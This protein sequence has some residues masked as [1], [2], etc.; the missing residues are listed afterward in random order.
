MIL[1]QLILK[2]NYRHIIVRSICRRCTN[3]VVCID[4]LLTIEVTR[5]VCAKL[6]KDVTV[7]N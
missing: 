3:T 2:Y 6:Q 4:Q 7:Y 1:R 5:L